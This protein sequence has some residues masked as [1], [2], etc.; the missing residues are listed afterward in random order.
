[1]SVRWRKGD[2][3]R[4]RFEDKDK[5]TFEFHGKD[6]AGQ[7]HLWHGGEDHIRMIPMR[8]FQK[9]CERSW[10][11][12]KL[13]PEKPEW[14]VEGARLK[15]G[16]TQVVVRRIELDFFSILDDDVL[17]FYK[18]ADAHKYFVPDITAW[19]LLDRDFLSEG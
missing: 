4:Y 10:V 9:D 2:F 15:W 7:V 8:T 5:P 3:G 11:I 6:K 14:L 19:D 18:I 1:M 16:G 13:K 12:K 17:R